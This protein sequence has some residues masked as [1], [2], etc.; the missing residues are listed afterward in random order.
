MNLCI[1]GTGYVGL[2]SAA[3]FAEM[4]N[5]VRC[6]DVNPKVVEGLRQG[7]IHI[8]EPGLDDLVKRNT[9][10]GRLTFTTDIKEGLNDA[11]FAFICVGTPSG[12]DGCCDL[13]YVH[14]V[15]KDIGRAMAGYLVVVDKSTVPVGTADAVRSLIAGELKARGSDLEFDVVSNPEFLKEGDAISDF[16][17]PDRVVVGT[18]NVRVAELMKALYAP[19]ARSREKLVVMGVK[20]AEMTKYAANCLLAAKISFINEVA[21]LCERVGADVR[22]VRIGIGSDHRIG[23]HFIYPGVGYGGSCFPKDVKALINTARENGVEPTLLAAVDSVNAAQKLSLAAKIEAH[24]A[25]QG[26]VKGK[27]LALWGLAFKANT[28]DVREAPALEMVRRLAAQGMVIKAYDPVAGPNAA[29]E[30]EGVAGF[31]L[32]ENEYAALEGADALAVVT[33]WNQFRNPDFGRIRKALS[34][35]V[36]FDGRNLYS[37]D[38]LAEQGFSYYGIGRAPVFPKALGLAHRATKSPGRTAGAFS[39][40]AL[41]GQ[42]GLASEALAGTQL[43]LLDDEALVFKGGGGRPGVL[44]FQEP[45]QILGLLP[46]IEQFVVA[47]GLD[48][49]LDGEVDGGGEELGHLV[50]LLGK[51][52]R[53]AGVCP[54]MLVQA[55]H[56]GNRAGLGGRGRRL[57]GD[58]A[59]GAVD[60][61]DEVLDLEGLGEEVVHL[62]AQGLHGGVQ[63]GEGGD[64]DHLHPGVALLDGA[65]HLHAVDALHLEVGDHHVEPLLGQPLQGRG[66]G[67]ECFHLEALLAQVHAGHVQ[68]DLL[69]VN[70]HDSGS[71]HRRVLLAGGSAVRR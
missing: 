69:V 41:V 38:F 21:G 7:K 54:P 28:D 49:L 47:Q 50:G 39:F 15:A 30:V 35:P 18:D 12:A 53:A 20:S 66:R 45:L 24:F 70:H 5:T 33:E 36:I 10:E 29:R 19:F 22:E 8:Y 59:Q 23:Y 57:P 26:G 46:E 40:M 48:L 64:H 3:C 67:Q 13:S 1:V 62:S 32:A 51:R 14:Q 63:V 58:A 25:S 61:G 2:V 11:L 71:A 37:P 68:D 17:K 9:A 43:Q 44:L 16:M 52:P 55:G 34:A 6:V 56:S 31:S 65:Q 4:G 42:L 27:T 60:G